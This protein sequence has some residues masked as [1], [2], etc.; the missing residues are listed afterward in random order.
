LDLPGH[1]PRVPQLVQ[2][3]EIGGWLGW[4]FVILSWG[5][6]ISRTSLRPH[7]KVGLCGTPAIRLD[8]TNLISL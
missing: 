8:K 6:S 4:S 5:I 2:A 3:L 1:L 7:A